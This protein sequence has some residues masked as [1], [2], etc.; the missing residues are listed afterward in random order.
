MFALLLVPEKWGEG[1]I[2]RTGLVEGVHV[3]SG[4]HS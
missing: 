2:D 1:I 3:K 4:V